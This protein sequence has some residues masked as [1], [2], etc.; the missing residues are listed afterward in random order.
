MRAALACAFLAWSQGIGAAGNVAFVADIHGSI[1]IEGDGALTFLVELGSGTRLLVGSHATATITYAASGAEFAI[2]GPGEFLVTPTEVKSERG[3]TPRLRQVAKLPDPATV[4][5]ISQA[6]TASLRMR[7]MRSPAPQSLI[8]Y[9][10]DTRIATLRPAIRIAAGA[11]RDVRLVLED[12]DGREIWKGRGTQA[13]NRLPVALAPAT[14]YR[15]VATA[16]GERRGEVRFETLPLDA[17]AL[18]EGSR[19]AATSFGE[20]VIH[21]MLLQ[22]LGADQDAQAEWAA[23]ARQRPDLPQLQSLAR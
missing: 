1:T 21:A 12:G 16:P 5:R 4:T 3:A 18:V 11:A 22:E 2:A 14:R 9:P 6:A 19:S 10:V 17:L 20:R 13:G 23:L 8:A 15:L 7:G